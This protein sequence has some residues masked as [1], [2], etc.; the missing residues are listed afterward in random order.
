MR[1]RPAWDELA[2]HD[3]FV[4]VQENTARSIEVNLAI[5]PTLRLDSVRES[6]GVGVSPKNQ[7]NPTRIK[8]YSTRLVQ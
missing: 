8:R 5:L 2:L 6:V 1:V 3:N 4:G 7:R